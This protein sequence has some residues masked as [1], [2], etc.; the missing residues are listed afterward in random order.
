M[1]DGIPPERRCPI[2][3]SLTVN[4]HPNSLC[5]EH[6]PAE[7]P[8]V[9]P[10]DN[11]ETAEPTLAEARAVAGQESSAAPERDLEVTRELELVD[12]FDRLSD[13]GTEVA[14]RERPAH[15]RSA[16]WT[17]SRPRNDVER[18]IVFPVIL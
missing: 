10:L 12:R 13:R 11:A 8:T 18:S 9:T 7:D 5:P 4:A 15:S 2:C 14:V 1:T 3:G 16:S 17:H 6:H